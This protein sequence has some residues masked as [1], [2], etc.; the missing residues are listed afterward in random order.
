MGLIPFAVLT[1]LLMIAGLVTTILFAV[2]VWESVVRRTGS[3]VA[4]THPG[5]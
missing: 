4:R 1:D 5:V 3:T 2:A